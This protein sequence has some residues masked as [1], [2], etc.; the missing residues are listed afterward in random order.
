MCLGR[1]K[2]ASVIIGAAN[3]GSFTLVGVLDETALARG[4]SC[5]HLHKQLLARI[6]LCD[7][8]RVGVSF[9]TTESS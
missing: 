6:D 8:H 7:G 3:R 4:A 5:T 1:Q 9:G 2:G